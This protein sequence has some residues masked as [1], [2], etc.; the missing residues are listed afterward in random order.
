MEEGHKHLAD[1]ET[2][3]KPCTGNSSI[4]RDQLKTRAIQNKYPAE[5][6]S[7]RVRF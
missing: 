1:P 2:P 7:V 4:I 5:I 6:I 3:K